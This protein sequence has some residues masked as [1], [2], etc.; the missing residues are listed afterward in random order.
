MRRH[1]RWYATISYTELVCNWCL[2]RV[3]ANHNLVMEQL[4]CPL[5]KHV[6]LKYGIDKEVENE[7]TL[8][9]PAQLDLFVR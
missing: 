5:C 9:S 6:I 1:P 8:V 2:Q 7:E 3:Y 4:E